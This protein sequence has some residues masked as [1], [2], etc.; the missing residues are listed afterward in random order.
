MSWTSIIGQKQQISVLQKAIETGRLPH[1]YLFTG[2]EAAGKENVAFELART[3]NCRTGRENPAEGSCG[4]CPDCQQIANFL[5]P[6]IEYLFPIEAALLEAGETAKKENKKSIEVKERYE[7]LIEE[8]KQNPYFTP[9]MER[10][11]G[12]LSEQIVALQQKALYMPAA[13]KRKIFIISQAER[14]NPTAANKLL[15]LLEEP[16]A[17]IMFML[18][19]SR[20]ESVL[21]TIRSRCQVITFNRPTQTELESW[22]SQNRTDIAETEISFIVNF[23]RGNLALAW[24]LINR[25]GSTDNIPAIQLRNLAIEYLRLM[26]TPKRFHEALNLSETHAKNLSKKELTLFLGALLLFFQD[27]NHR[28]IAPGYKP[29]NNPDIE[30]SIDRFASNFPNPDF[31]AISTATE[32]AIRS[33][34]RNAAPLLVLSAWTAEIRKLI[35][36]K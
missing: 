36:A 9:A 22:L 20:P 11:M 26:L 32:E 3:L 17:H 29:L 2:P 5:H 8:K 12:I 24:E 31:L 15:K 16:P 25:N 23:S 34:D 14:M 28:I 35:L 13:G 27:I 4:A 21:P 6:N 7:E 30:T 1:A 33:I 18:I 19:S 10:S